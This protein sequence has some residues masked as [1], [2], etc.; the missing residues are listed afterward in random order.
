MTTMFIPP[1]STAI[2][3]LRVV[4]PA[5]VLLSTLSLISARP[6]PPQSPSPITPVVVAV[7]TPRRAAILAL[8]S[9]SACTFFLDGATFV[10]FAVLNKFWPRY[11]GIEINSIIGLI[12][13]AGLAA[14]GAW[15]DITGVNVWLL[16]RVKATIIIALVLDAAQVIVLGMSIHSE[17]TLVV[18]SGARILT[19]VP[20]RS[21]ERLLHFAFP[22]FRVLILVPL[23]VALLT[24]RLIYNPVQSVEEAS[25]TDSSLLLPA[26]AG[27]TA[28]T[29]L[30][31]VT[32]EASKYGTFGSAT[33]QRSG[34]TTRAGTPTPSTTHLS[35]NKVRI[36]CLIAACTC[37]GPEI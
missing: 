35:P 34:L 37:A 36:E 18:L 7:R 28:S 32:A 8:L 31:P 24:P 23:A 12:A 10:V 6:V 16:K 21:I 22:A 13:F 26:E 2:F 14:L 5:I 9:L 3:A 17:R 29:G 4:S 25:P 1:T 20:G 33:T 27:A 11:S 15:K 30:S 19:P